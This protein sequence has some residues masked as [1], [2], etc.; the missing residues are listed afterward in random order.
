MVLL[1]YVLHVIRF[2]QIVGCEYVGEQ[3][4]GTRKDKSGVVG[5]E[6]D[7]N[8]RVELD[9]Q[10]HADKEFTAKLNMSRYLLFILYR[11]KY[12]SM[13]NAYITNSYRING[14]RYFIRV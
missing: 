6:C 10:H 12:A 11:L 1:L 9:H 8:E 14:V 7:F 3:N 4:G 2:H 13:Y 5:G